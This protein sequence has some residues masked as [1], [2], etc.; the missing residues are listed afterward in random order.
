VPDYGGSDDHMMWAQLVAKHLK[1]SELCNG[2]TI[3]EVVCVHIAAATGEH[4]SWN[5]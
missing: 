5:S 2:P 3:E 1:P 4:G